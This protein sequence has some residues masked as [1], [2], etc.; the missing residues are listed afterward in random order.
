V[1]QKQRHVPRPHNSGRVA[2]HR[3]RGT[4]ASNAATA[5]HVQ[6]EPE[7]FKNRIES[8]D[9]IKGLPLFYLQA[10]DLV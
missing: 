6:Q 10:F 2:G 1:L 4:T 9:P 3:T 8:G 5:L 7:H